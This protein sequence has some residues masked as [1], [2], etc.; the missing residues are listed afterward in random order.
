M[1]FI[2]ASQSPRRRE[3]L[4]ALGLNFEVV[5]SEADESYDKT[6]APENVVMTLAAKK[7][8]AVRKKLEEKKVDLSDTVII[9]ADTVVACGDVILGK[10]CD[11]EDAK[12]MMHLIS[13]N[14]H[15]VYSGICVVYRGK[16][17]SAFEETK[18]D[19]AKM[20]ESEIEWYVNTSEPF[21]KAG[22]YAVQGYASL[23]IKGI[24]GDYFNVVG[25]P[26]NCLSRLM[27]EG[28]GISLYEHLNVDKKIEKT[29]M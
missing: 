20:S 9:A 1:N 12:K 28:F 11:A 4:S 25:L 16:S 5:T 27:S 22:G 19:F 21:D 24:E 15:S 7:A 17:A 13:D 23:W 6:L 10:P 2:L 26:V 14:M 29:T 18:V 8:I 3:I